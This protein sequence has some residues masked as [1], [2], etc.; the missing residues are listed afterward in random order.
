MKREGNLYEQIYSIDNLKL[1]EKR[2]RRGKSKQSGVIEFHN[3][4]EANIINLY[5]LLKNKEFK[6]SD[7][8]VFKLYDG[9]ER[10]IYQ[11][12]YSPDRIVHHA[13]ANITE[14]IFTRSLTF[15]TYSCIRKRGI[16]LCLRKLN[17]ALKN[18]DN[19]YCL[20]IDIKKYYPSIKNDILKKLLR[21]KFKDKDL[22]DLFDN[23]ID[24]NVGLPIG[25]YMSQIFGNFY[26]NYFD[27]YLKEVLKIKSTYRYCDDIVILSNNKDDL[28]ITLNKIRIYLKDNLDL[29]L[30]NYQIFPVTRGIDFLGYVSYPTHIRLRKSIK[31]RYIKMKKYNDNIRSNTSYNGWLLH[32]NSINLKNKYKTH[33]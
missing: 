9:K 23:I 30:S 25:N 7:Y 5:H 2:A 17:K 6:T 18:D 20:K 27:H 31:L 22:L 11:L 14:K 32:C 24:S 29:E 21:K 28:R 16:H 8:K 1:A 4:Y 15:D 13:I 10:D 19:K 26:L 3:N 12:P 33:E